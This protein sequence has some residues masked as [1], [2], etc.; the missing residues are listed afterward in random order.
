[1]DAQYFRS[2]NLLVEIEVPTQGML[3]RT[4]VNDESVKI[5]LFGFAPGHELKAHAAPVPATIQVLNGE[6][7]LTLGDETCEALAG[8]LVHMPPGL[9]HG[10]VAR[11]AFRMLLILHKTAPRS[12]DAGPV[13]TTRN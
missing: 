3:S 6:A 1:M 13:G 7:T 12:S 11:T 4:L 8:C 2:P 9:V 10:V 5:I